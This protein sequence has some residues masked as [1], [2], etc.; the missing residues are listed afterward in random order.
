M[1]KITAKK[2][3]RPRTIR[4]NETPKR[5]YVLEYKVSP[6]TPAMWIESEM[7]PE[8][9]KL[10]T[11]VYCHK[12]GEDHH[13]LGWF[14]SVGLLTK[15]HIRAKQVVR[16]FLESPAGKGWRCFDRRFVEYH[17]GAARG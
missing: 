1:A 8:Q 7:T 13:L 12:V 4:V 9:W 11:K 14:T 10:F 3:T 17:W 5:T 6:S 16:D 2:T 15:S